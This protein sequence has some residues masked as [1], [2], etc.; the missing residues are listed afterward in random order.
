MMNRSIFPILCA[1]MFHSP[2][3]LGHPLAAEAIRMEV[4]AR[5]APA[6]GAPASFRPRVRT[7]AGQDL[8]LLE[9]EWN[10][11]RLVPLLDRL[12]GKALPARWLTRVDGPPGDLAGADWLRWWDQHHSASDA[13][14]T[15]RGLD[16]YDGANAALISRTAQEARR[17]IAALGSTITAEQRVQVLQQVVHQTY[18]GV[19]GKV[20]R[21]HAYLAMH[22]GRQL[23]FTVEFRCYGLTTSGHAWNRV[24]TGGQTFVLDAF[25]NIRYTSNGKAKPPVRA[26]AVVLSGNQLVQNGQLIVV[27]LGIAVP[28]I[29]GSYRVRLP[30]AATWTLLATVRNQ[31]TGRYEQGQ[32]TVKPVLNSEPG[33]TFPAPVI[34]TEPN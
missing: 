1:L 10:R 16:L 32:T 12:D 20:C 8:A 21:H 24:T 4:P 28:I 29:N 22:A 3:G 9:A 23:G 11:Q 30:V 31:Q 34:R 27:E 17:A 2:L 18:A 19:A 26:A 13:W 15:I 25:N 7:L 14:W 5:P 33:S 6:G